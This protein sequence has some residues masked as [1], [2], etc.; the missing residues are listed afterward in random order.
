MKK[1]SVV[2]GLVMALMV[3]M[4]VSSASAAEAKGKT[5][6][7]IMPT[8]EQSI[9]T[10]QGERIQ[11]SFEAAGYDTMIEY[12]EDDSAKQIMQIENMITKG[13]DVL[14]IAAVDCAALTEPCEKAK[15]EGILVIA[16]DRNITNTEAVDYYV[17]CDYPKL[18]EM[19]GQW[20]A[21][22][23]DLENA[24]GPFT[25]EIFTGS[26]DDTN[27]AIFYDGQM[28]ILQPY[29]DS[30][31]LVVK[32]GQ[33][34]LSETATQSWDTSKA[35]NRMD[36]LLSGYYSD[37]HLDVA[38]CTSDCLSI[39]VLSS[40]ESMG[41]GTEDNPLPLITGQDAELAAVKNIVAGKQSMTVFIDA[42]LMVEKMVPLVDKLLAGEEVEP[43]AYF[44]N[45][46]F[47]VPT[48][49]YEP[50]VIDDTNVDYLIEVGFY[51]EEEIYG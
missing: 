38:L 46:V 29:I 10:V 48:M 33:T 3:C 18:A 26:Q 41:Y 21:D 40:L 13:V 12:A 49:T 34:S 50:L 25:M 5:I 17:T 39:G 16:D 11:E 30:G 24:E 4:M 32:S 20:V 45:E 6:G 23:L 19:Q 2:M 36:N 22:T 31:K 1:T 42:N 8:K 7:I 14:I 35:Q 9:W 27:S 47:D 37:D 44:N 15:K 28:K 43:D 51:T